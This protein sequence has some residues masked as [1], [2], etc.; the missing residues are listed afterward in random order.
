[1]N[2][3]SLE[4][5][6]K[7]HAEKQV[8]SEV[9][10]GIDDGDRVGVIGVNGSGK[11]TLLRLIAGAEEPD[12]GRVVL[13][14]DARVHYLPQEPGLD[15]ADTPLQAVL[16]GIEAPQ[17]RAEEML[18]R[19]GVRDWDRP[20]SERSGGERKRV[21][22]ARALADEANVLILDEPTNHLDVDVIEW[23]E[24]RLLGWQGALILVTHDRYLLDDVATRIVEVE[25]GGIHTGYGNYADYL[26][27]RAVREE[28]AAA[29]ERKRAN[30]TRTELEWL[31]RGPKARTSKAK[32]RVERAKALVEFRAEERRRDVEIGLPS[33]R[34]GSKVVNLHNVGKRFADG[35]G[36]RWVLRGV[37]HK[38]APDARIGLVGP[39]GSGKST[40]LRLIVGELE[41]DEGKVVV[42]ETI[43]PGFYRQ[44][45]TPMPNTRVIDALKEVVLE[46]NTVEGITLSASQLLE[47]FLFTGEAQKAYVEELSGGERR[48]LELLRVLATA[49]NLLLLDE[50]TNDLDLDTLRVLE[51][52]LDGWQGALVVAS[53]DR[54]FLDRVCDDIWSV[55]PDGSLRHHPGGWSAYQAAQ[56]QEQ[57][58]AAAAASQPLSTGEQPRGERRR[59]K[60]G[61]NETRELAL[62]SERIPQLEARRAQLERAVQE[63]GAD[64]EAAAEAGDELATLLAELDAAETRWLELSEF[65]DDGT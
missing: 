13:A 6:S 46:T 62:L 51:E 39:N 19:L 59:R 15:P 30:R 64:Y 29:E 20:V 4:R 57:E 36:E 53:H 31:R 28:Q 2:L 63:A 12:D 43:V 58:R 11:S 50:P 8:L 54:Y 45:P 41:P 49:P 5:V 55:Q 33:R 25:R 9:T 10:L 1:M 21:A 35:A 32:Y 34:I 52:Y 18:D 23:L 3:V 16:R 38:L 65:A 26:Q 7:R 22:L 42:G 44:E 56:E 37:E 14:N 48:R 61:Y 27:T 60:L 17:H 24:G 40:L 47:R